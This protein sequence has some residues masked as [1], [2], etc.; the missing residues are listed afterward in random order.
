MIF[1]STRQHTSAAKPEPQ[2]ANPGI[3]LGWG[4][5]FSGGT[6]QKP[7]QAT[8]QPAANAPQQQRAPVVQP[9][10][11]PGQG[12]V[13][14]A[15][16]Q[17][18]QRRPEAPSADMS[19]RRDPPLEPSQF[20][21]SSTPVQ[22]QVSQQRPP[23][24]ATQPPA[25]QPVAPATFPGQGLPTPQASQQ[26]QRDPVQTAQPA[27][28]ATFPGQGQ[29]QPYGGIQ[30][31]EPRK[32]PQFLDQMD[33]ARAMFA[34]QR[35]PSAPQSKIQT[36]PLG[37]IDPVQP[38]FAGMGNQPTGIGYERENQVPAFAEQRLSQLD[39]RAMLGLDRRQW[40][41]YRGPGVDQALFSQ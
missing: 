14:A 17:Q 22:A 10:T 21:Q 7:K 11:F 40:E 6:Q 36:R 23:V 27:A 20:G 13:T 32:N 8:P 9:A 3:N 41:Q 19:Y 30:R 4:S 18:Q 12:P 35:Q 25:V 5:R 28:P 15:P 34:S 33:S 31:P 37:M 39:P 16:A 24:Q 38:R 26:R 2:R 1:D 29:L